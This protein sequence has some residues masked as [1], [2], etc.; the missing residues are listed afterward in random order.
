M[1]NFVNIGALWNP[2]EGSKAIFTG[3]LGSASLFIFETEDK[4]LDY[5]VCG[6]NPKKKEEDKPKNDDMPF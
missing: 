6:A 3:K 4:H 2:K 5:V 1:S